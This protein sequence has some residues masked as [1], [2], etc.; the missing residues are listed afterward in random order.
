MRAL[1]HA[2][3]TAGLVILATVVGT[4]AGLAADD[5]R[6]TFDVT[7]IGNEGFLVQA[8]GKKV[9]VDALFTDGFGQYLAP[10][11]ELLAQMT[12]AQDP[13]AGID[14]IL[15]THPH[16]DHFN[17]KPVVAH[18]RNNPHARLIAHTQTVDQVRKE[19][20]FAQIANQVREV[21]LQPG[22]RE[23]IVANDIT[24]DALCLYHA[25]AEGV[26]L[27]SRNLAFV[28]D[29]GGGARFLHAGDATLEKSAGH[30]GAFSFDAAPIDVLFL[31]YFDRSQATRRLIARTLKPSRIIAMHVPPAQLE[32]ESKKT[33]AV[34][35]H[36]IVFKQSMERRS[37]PIEVDFH[38]LSGAYFGQ[39]LPDA[40]P[41]VFA[42][43]IVSTDANEHSVPSFSPDGNEVF[44]WANRWPGPDNKEWELMSMTMRRENGRWS[45]PHV[46]SL[47]QM[48]ALTPDGRRAYFGEEKDIWVAEKQGDDWGEPKCLNLVGRYP[49][50]RDVFMPT[51]ARNGTLYFMGYTPGPRNDFGIFRTEL[52][53]GE[54]ATPELLPRSIN[55]PPF[56][57]WAPFIAPDESYLLFSS[58][59]R[60]PDHDG[61]DLYISRRLAD[62]TWTDPIGLGE[63]VNTPQQEVFPGL[64]P[65]G[66][67]LFFCRSTPD[68]Y[69]EVY[70]VSAASIPLLRG[71]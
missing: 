30:L 34:Y 23:R 9:L 17:P 3:R 37:L 63:P 24:V 27:G 64:S 71:R 45:A 51:I 32:E 68:R 59:R 18:L 14:L 38:N 33:R 8:A 2:A 4:A 46:T 43:G 53:N 1:R 7:Y 40:T 39:P 31:E 50:L 36:A 56:L 52:V 6:P 41:Q 42:R 48:V 13:F 60:D 55:P 15:V 61:G 22:A 57:N 67:Y 16:G 47:G 58:N 49:E 66:K 21:R 12:S 70:W 35:P 65:D 11:P 19:E 44:W 20:G 28:V 10:V 69:N 54:Y 26:D 5:P 25:A 62:G 29:L